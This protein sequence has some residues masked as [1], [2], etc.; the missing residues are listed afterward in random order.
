M[1][2]NVTVTFDDGSQHVYQNAPDDITPEM[3]T[4]RASREF[5][6]TVT[7]LDGGRNAQPVAESA[8][9]I[10]TQQTA[11]RLHRLEGLRPEQPAC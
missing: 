2:R 4:E 6:K 5:G 7:A 8:R 1:A 9:S 10:E 11:P 3:V